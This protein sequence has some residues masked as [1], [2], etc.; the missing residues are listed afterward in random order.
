[1]VRREHV[2]ILISGGGIA[3]L[4]AAGTFG[5]AGLSVLCVDPAILP[6]IDEDDPD[7][8]T[9]AFLQPAR[10]LLSA[11]GL[12]ERFAPR[13]T[14]LQAMRIVDV[15]ETDDEPREIREFNAADI[16]GEPF[17]WN[18]PNGF[19]RREILSHLETL[20]DARFVPGVAVV[21][22][23]TREREARVTLS[24][25]TQVSAR[26]VIA[27]DGRDSPVRQAAGVGTRTTR[28]GQKALAFTVTHPVPHENVSTEIHRNGGPFT[29]VPL[30]DRD[31]RPCSAVI[32]ME[33]G[34]EALRLSELPVP[35]FEEAIA[36]RSCGILGPLSLIGRRSIW[37][38]ISRITDR[39]YA[40]RIAL[41]AEA[42]HVVPPI[43]AQGLN[44]S[45]GDL[46]VLLDLAENAPADIGTTDMLVRYHRKRYP[47]IRLRLAAI[48]TL[49]RVSMAAPRGMRAA[50]LGALHSV[51]PVRRALMRAGMGT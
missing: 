8:R 16:S 15:G 29:L 34:P 17:G 43:G 4:T 5:D 24:D 12:W 28:Y 47:E 42:A 1:M 44:M 7:L 48:G 13:A 31:D 25:G 32:W 18:L 33:T 40:Q 46:R 20:P 26:L 21:R 36:A 11:C 49:N 38:I 41:I 27:A 3:G 39:M 9:T 30:P 14:P 22:V 23:A 50:A 19:L 51:P 2:D 35:E 45:L 37:P 6:A 10:N